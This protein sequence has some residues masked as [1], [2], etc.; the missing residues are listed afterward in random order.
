MH[1]PLEV[2]PIL[3][4]PHHTVIHSAFEVRIGRGAGP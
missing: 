4:L 3:L 1:Q 2:G